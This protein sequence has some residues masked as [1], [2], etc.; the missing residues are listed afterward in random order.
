MKPATV[1]KVSFA[2]AALDL[3]IAAVCATNGDVHFVAF[4]ILAGL[5]Y[6]HGLYFKN[7]ADKEI[8][9]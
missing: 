1:Y 5:M 4:M 2:L 8:G 3:W 7:R 6:G 9:E